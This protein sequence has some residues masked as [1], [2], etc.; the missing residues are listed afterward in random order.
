MCFENLWQVVIKSSVLY[1]VLS[2][3]WSQKRGQCTFDSSLARE[4]TIEDPKKKLLRD[5]KSTRLN[6]SH[7]RRSRMPSSA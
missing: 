4:Y 5:R 1:L 2:K 3:G 6:S 7:E